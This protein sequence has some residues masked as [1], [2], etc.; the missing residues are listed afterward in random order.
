MQ[1]DMGLKGSE[2]GSDIL[3]ELAQTVPIGLL[4]E[5]KKKWVHC[6]LSLLH[7]LSLLPSFYFPLSQIFISI[8][9]LFCF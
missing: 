5:I 4:E 2:R 8:L 6:H 7:T 9:S 1:D 3:P